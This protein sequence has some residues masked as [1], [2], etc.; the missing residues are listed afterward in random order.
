LCREPTAEERQALEAYAKAHGLPNTCR[1]MLN[2]N[3][4]VFVD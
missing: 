1:V 4:F 3:E 2:L